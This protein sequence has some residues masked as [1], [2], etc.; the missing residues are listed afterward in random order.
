LASLA[1]RG[2][3]IFTVLISVPLTVHYLGAEQYGLW[4][5][6]TS[7]V[8]L[9][10]FAD[11]GL[12]NGLMN[13]VSEAHG[14]GDR[15]L[16]QADVSSAFYLLGGAA[17][18]L[19]LAFAAAYGFVPW[20]GVFNVS[21]STAAAVAG[22]ATVVFVGITL[23]SLPFGVVPKI[24]LGYQ[25]GFKSSI[26]D[27]VGNLLSLGGL[28]LAVAAKASLPWLILAIGVGPLLATLLNGAA[29]LR[30]RPWLAPRMRLATRFAA[31]HIVRLGLGFFVLQLVA[32]VAYQTDNVVI[33]Q[34]LG[35]AA[36]TQ[37]AVPMRLFMTVPLLLSFWLMPLWPAYREALTRGD[38]AWVRRTLIRSL[39]I[40][41]G[42]SIP[43]S[44]VLVLF[45]GPLLNLWVGDSVTPTT[46]LLLALGLWMVVYSVSITMAV[47]LNGANVIGF[48]VVIAIC[49]MVVNLGLS[50]VLTHL[51]GVS[52]PAWGSTVAVTF[53]V[54]LPDA[55]YV[56]RLLRASR[57]PELRNADDSVRASS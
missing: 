54:L 17:T 27:A 12:S 25:E 14:K 18:V 23:V 26:W 1:A 9:F 53:C 15:E 33:A 43:L 6:I 30:G 55:W 3:G 39:V 11:L 49:M 5:T 24:R 47:F 2:V 13:A 32:V 10:G 29:L 44:A 45:G 8:V 38:D 46:S 50:I 41:V 19:A 56:R 7:V 57:S 37:Y 34:I 28:V 40:S 36:V 20:S 42:V 52:G 51:V 31:G 16:A 22:Q 35:V 4:V 21:S 48:Q